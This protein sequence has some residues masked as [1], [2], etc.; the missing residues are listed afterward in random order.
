MKSHLLIILLISNILCIEYT[1]LNMNKVYNIET[2]D[3]E[4]NY[5]KFNLRHLNT[6][7]NEITIQTDLINSPPSS[8][9][10]VGVHYEPI[11]LK[12]YKNL[13]KS[14]LGQPIKLNNEFIKSALQN[15]DEIYMAIYSKN[16][17]YKINI[18]PNG[19]LDLTTNFIQAQPIRKLTQENFGANNDTVINETQIERLQF[20]AG[21]G[22]S[23]LI[24]A[25]IL[26]FVSLIACGIM[27]NIY[28]HTT[29]LVEQPLKLGKIEA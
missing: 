29:A 26:I 9:P 16:S 20:Y 15:K 5:F 10:I 6:I 23:A 24:V 7:P 12:N 11:K 21:D 22:L 4:F 1:E 27:M 17:K 18:I 25:F 14:K 2:K 19:E 3:E 13:S 8:S 28:V